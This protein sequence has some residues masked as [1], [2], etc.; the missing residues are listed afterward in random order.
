MEH[1]PTPDQPAGG[2]SLDIVARKA[3][4][5]L[6][7]HETD[8]IKEWLKRIIDD[9]GLFSLQTFPTREL[10]V[11]FPELISSLARAISKPDIDL[12]GSPVLTEVA[13][14]LATLRK[15]EPDV[16]KM[17]DDYSL[18]KQLLLEA[19]AREMRYTDRLALGVARRLDE[20]FSQILK[21]GLT[22]YIER[23]SMELQHLANTDAMTGLYNVRYFRHQ[24]HR[25]LEMFK[26]YR[27]PFSLVM[28]DL[29]KLKQLNDAC[30]HQYGD[31]ALKNLAAIMNDEKRET[32][33]AVRYGGDEFFIVLPGTA[34]EEAERLALRVNQRVQELNLETGGIE[35]TGVSI[36][37]VSCP[38]NGT[39][40]GTLRAR[41]DRALY[42]AK[43]I[44]GSTVARY[45]EFSLEPQVI[46]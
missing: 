32:D 34:T 2:D 23:H 10:T 26:R 36:G 8:V 1:S 25:N 19:A 30:G 44:G 9:L 4:E 12:S 43:S 37:V 28:I 40:V 11:G 22:A 45:H 3:S 7:E 33:V 14:L 42:L 15:E 5:S 20:G 38:A 41:A 39:D 21:A 29:D 35:M 13:A 27:I 24:L 18:L 6:L 17:F 31:R 16:G 46:F